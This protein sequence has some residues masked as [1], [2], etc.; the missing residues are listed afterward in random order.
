M[1]R[2]GIFKKSFWLSRNADC[3]CYLCHATRKVGLPGTTLQLGSV[4]EY[5]CG[6]IWNQGVCFTKPVVFLVKDF[7]QRR[8]TKLTERIRSILHPGCSLLLRLNH[9]NANKGLVPVIHPGSFPPCVTF[10]VIQFR[11]F[12]FQ[13][14]DNKVSFQLVEVERRI[15]G[16]ISFR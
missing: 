10:L 3:C 4:V 5:L 13:P 9:G 2:N 11:N 15:W 16:Y 14:F 7:P 12:N 1:N 8:L 6:R